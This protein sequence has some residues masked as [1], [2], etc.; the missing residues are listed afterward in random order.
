M[1]PAKNLFHFC[2]VLAALLVVPAISGAER[3]LRAG[4]ATI[5]VGQTNRV[6]I[7]L[8]SL[9]DEKAL[10]FSLS[11]DTNLLRFVQAVLGP[12]A[13]NHGAS[14]TVNANQTTNFGRI[15]LALSL[16]LF[17]TNT[18][19]A[20][21]NQIAELLFTPAPGITGG[22][23]AIQFTNAPIVPEIADS[24]ASNLTAT[25]VSG[26]ATVELNCAF[27]LGTNAAGFAAS[28]GTGDVTLGTLPACGWLVSNTNGWI[29]IT[30]PTNGTGNST[31]Q[32][33]VAA[34]TGLASRTGVVFIAGQI[35]TITQSGITCSYLLST[36]T[37]THP[38]AAGTNSFALLTAGPCPWSVINSNSWIQ[39]L[40]DTSG[41]GNGTI[42]YAVDEN[43]SITPRSG[44]LIAGGQAFTI[45]QEAIVCTFSLS[46]T[47]AFHTE[48]PATNSF[49][50]TTAAPCP[51]SVVNTNPW[52]AILSDQSGTG[53]GTVTYAVSQSASITER[54]GTLVVG[55]QTFSITQQAVT[56]SFAVAPT[57]FTNSA[58]GFTNLITVSAPGPC[59][60]T[61]ESTNSWITIVSGSNGLGPG[62]V[63]LA[64][65]AN[66]ISLERTGTVV[67]AGQAVTILQQ[68]IACTFTV[69]PTRRTHGFG[70]ASNSFTINAGTGCL[71]SVVNTNPWLTIV[72]SSAGSGTNT[73]GYLVAANPSPLER[74][75]YLNVQGATLLITQRAITCTFTLAPTNLLHTSAGGTATV[76][77]TVGAGCAWTATT[78]D[79]WISLTTPSGTGNGAFG[80]AVEPNWSDAARTGAVNVAGQVLP[81]SQ[82]AYAGGFVLRSLDVSVPGQVSLSVTG[83]P[84]GVWELQMSGDLTNWSKLADLT[85]STGRVDLA[86]PFTTGSNHFFRALRP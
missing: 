75:G 51:W 44:T 5:A 11:Y 40:S 4:H 20:G 14:L 46:A 10:G 71:W 33:T 31:V 8:E 57:S 55:G 39:V 47:G 81:I 30:S 84:A 60:W 72:G 74:I 24:Y 56:C 68:G 26:L 48:A 67:V 61:V 7:S 45:T 49:S 16:D 2:A 69:S 22:V 53:S 59:P 3:T 85:N 70:T 29:S 82:A 76:S 80:V 28:G 34:N 18:F 77:V 38:T 37:A 13:T 21:T 17:T 66:A 32:F 1:K 54:T 83:G 63:Q 25:Y 36:N 62:G 6:A 78:S 86:V 64:L 41:S 50:V 43:A 27:A 12:D 42:T 73:V 79:A 58:A 9:G 65:A 23:S 35:F 52:I 19:P 15:G